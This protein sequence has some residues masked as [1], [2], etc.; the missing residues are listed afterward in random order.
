MSADVCGR[1]SLSGQI[2]VCEPGQS[3]WEWLAAVSA[4]VCDQGKPLLCMRSH[5][6]G[7]LRK[8]KPKNFYFWQMSA[9]L[10]TKTTPKQGVRPWDFDFCAFLCR[11]ANIATFPDGEI[12]SK[13]ETPT[14]PQTNPA[15]IKTDAHRNQCV[16]YVKIKMVFGFCADHA[17]SSWRTKAASSPD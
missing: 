15:C 9:A 1:L 10:E 16:C 17:T 7:C 12:H 5:V 2:Y 4:S 13:M 14:G 6:C 8:E 11:G 3:A